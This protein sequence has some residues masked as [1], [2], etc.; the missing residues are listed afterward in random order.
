MQWELAFRPCFPY[1]QKNT[2]LLGATGTLL[3]HSGHNGGPWCSTC[4]V[5]SYLQDRSTWRGVKLPK[6]HTSK[7]TYEGLS[8]EVYLRRKD[9]PYLWWH[10]RRAGALDRVNR[11]AGESGW[12]TIIHLS[13]LPYCRYNAALSS[14]H[15]A[16]WPWRSNVPL[17]ISL[18]SLS[19]FCGLFLPQWGKK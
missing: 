15:H 5:W 16:P 3:C 1:L 8:R 11:W 18:L 6:R 17:K 2:V 13:L 12:G 14:L 9:P 10:H 4:W 19:V 7:C